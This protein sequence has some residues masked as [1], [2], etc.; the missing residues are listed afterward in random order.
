MAQERSESPRTTEYRGH[1]RLAFRLLLA[2]YALY[3]A[4]FIFRTSYRVDGERYF[5]LF[6]DE[7]ISMRYAFN[8][9]HGAGLVWNPGGERVEGYSNPA[10]VLLMAGAHLL[11]LPQSKVSVVIQICGA[12]F[13]LVSLFHVKAIAE[14]LGRSAVAAWGAALLTAAYLPLANWGLQGTEVS[15]LTLIVTSATRLAMRALRARELRLAPYLLLGL[16]TLIRLDMLVPALAMLL[17]L[18]I[19]DRDHRIR[20]LVVGAAIL[21]SVL[22]AQTVFRLAYY[23]DVLPNPY[24]LKLTG[25]PVSARIARGVAV[26]WLFISRVN[27]VAFLVPLAVLV[28]RRDRCVLLLFWLFGVQ[29][30]YSIYVGGDAWEWWGGSNRF[31]C[32]VMPLYFVLYAYALWE[33]TARLVGRVRAAAPRRLDHQRRLFVV[34]LCIAMVNINDIHD[35]AL[36]EWLLLRR[37]LNVE[38]NSKYVRT[39]LALRRLTTPDARVAVVWAGATPYFANRPAIDLLG[40]NDARVARED[41]HRPPDLLTGF[42]PGHLKWNLAYSIGELEPD[43]V[44]PWFQTIPEPMPFS[45]RYRHVDHDGIQLLLRSDSSKIRWSALPAARSGSGGPPVD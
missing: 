3:A 12:L 19:A 13:L 28:W 2:A 35:G 15:A 44:V 32:I 24:Y 9:V 42:Y 34:L 8:L 16:G 37:T 18:G 26:T 14:L 11:P 43:V 1:P 5:S 7:M 4:L 6:D 22:L 40:K 27:P 30:L 25:Y 31:V 41:M 33:L 38:A 20:H 39:G 45:E 10:W 21:A 29:M 23:G 17:F 36:H